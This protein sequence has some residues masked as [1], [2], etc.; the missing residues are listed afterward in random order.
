L[1]RNEDEIAG[2]VAHELG[3]VIA[4]HNANDMS[5]LFREI[6]GV[7]QL[8]DRRDIFEKY[9]L[10]IENR[11]RKPKAEDKLGSREDRDQYAADMV[12]LYVMAGAGYNAQAQAGFWDRY[13]ETKG[14][15]GSFLFEPLR[16]NQTGTEAACRDVTTAVS[17]AG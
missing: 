5:V 15:T 6:L 4:R 10:F 16:Y 7:T 1:R 17:F 3:H 13:Q 8:G 2:V 9:H 14:K 12:G 11:K